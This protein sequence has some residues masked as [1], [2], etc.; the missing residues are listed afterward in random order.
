[1]ILI[2]FIRPTVILRREAA[3][4]SPDTRPILDNFKSSFSGLAVIP[5]GIMD[6]ISSRYPLF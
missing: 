1:M 5:K 4:Q 2:M 3:K 6:N